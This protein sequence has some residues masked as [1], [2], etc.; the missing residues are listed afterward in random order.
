[1]KKYICMIR[2]PITNYSF[3]NQL[4]WIRYDGDD[5]DDDDENEDIREQ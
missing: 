5:D 3:Y 1:M 4:I 2:N